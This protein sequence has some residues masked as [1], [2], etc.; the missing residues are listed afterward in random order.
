[1]GECLTEVDQVVRDDA[2]ADPA[3][4]AGHA[5]VATAAESMA[6]FE[7]TDAPLTA[8]APFLGV[9]EPALLLEL[10]A[11]RALGGAIWDGHP[12]DAPGPGCGLIAQRE[13]GGI[14]SDQIG[15]SAQELL[16]PLD[17]AQQQV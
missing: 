3:L 13:E 1:M 12:L 11:L 9:A 15:P 14:G 8:G 10:P 4:D 5:F 7:K 2:E 16:V 17:R 6:A